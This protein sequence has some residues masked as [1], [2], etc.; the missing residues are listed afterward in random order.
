M[1]TMQNLIVKKL[2]EAQTGQFYGFVPNLIDQLF[3]QYTTMG[4]GMSPLYF[5][6][7]PGT[8]AEC[9][10]LHDGD[11]DMDITFSSG[12][13][14][15]RDGTKVVFDPRYFGFFNQLLD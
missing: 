10:F 1:T 11:Y 4:N 9:F 15:Y 12:S 2:H 3:N 14:W 13:Y 6:T 7:D 5:Y 8:F